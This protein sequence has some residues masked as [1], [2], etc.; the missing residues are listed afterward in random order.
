MSNTL[1]YFL[2]SLSILL[3]LLAKTNGQVAS[4]PLDDAP[5]NV[6]LLYFTVSSTPGSDGVTLTW[7][8]ATEL[9][10]AGFEI[11]RRTGL[12]GEFIYLDEIGFIDGQGEPAMG[13]LYQEMDETAV[14]DQTY[15]YRLVEIEFNGN[16]VDLEEVT[17][18]VGVLPTPTPTRTPT[19]TPTATATTPPAATA[20]ATMMPTA[21]ATPLP[22][23]V[24]NPTATATP[25]PTNTSTPRPT[26]SATAV[27]NA[28]NPTNTST[29]RPAN[30]SPIATPADSGPNTNTNQTP[31]QTTTTGSLQTAVTPTATPPNTN[32]NVAQANQPEQAETDTDTGADTGQP[33]TGPPA[34]IGQ[35][36]ADDNNDLSITAP[37]RSPGTNLPAIGSA[38]QPN[39]PLEPSAPLQESEANTSWGNLLLLWGGFILAL[40]IFIGSVAGS[41][42]LFTRKRE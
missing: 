6:E 9:G 16:E 31:G 22:A 40:L 36:L 21:T 25:Q 32:N 41:I 5:T 1:R 39:Q 30:S 42:Y 33:T 20:T 26:A 12:T 11:Y 24:T 2:L 29:P 3:L 27:S 19:T 38:A 37:T 8:T 23:G 13:H 35:A 7:E 28:T 18:T 10:T 4:L 34:S 14:L 15:T 17:I